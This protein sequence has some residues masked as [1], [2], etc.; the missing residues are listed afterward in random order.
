MYNLCNHSHFAK[1]YLIEAYEKLKKF[2]YK[3]CFFLYPMPFL[4]KRTSQN[5]KDERCEMFFMEN[6]LSSRVRFRKYQD[7]GQFYWTNLNVKSDDIIIMGKDKV[8]KCF[9]DI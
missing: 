1:K 6:F 2:K 9:L 3:K 8:S 5:N 7:A 4:F